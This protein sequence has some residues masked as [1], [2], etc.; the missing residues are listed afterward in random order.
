MDSPSIPAEVSEFPDDEE[1]ELALEPLT[2]S[3][4][5]APPGEPPP[6]VAWF[7]MLF[8]APAPPD[9]SPEQRAAL[10]DAGGM[11]LRFP[12][13]QPYLGAA[14]ATTLREIYGLYGEAGVAALAAAAENV[15]GYFERMGRTG[16][17]LVPAAIAAQREQLG[18]LVEQARL[19]V[20]RAANRLAVRWVRLARPQIAS[21]FARYTGL[22][23]ASA[24]ALQHTLAFQLQGP[25]TVALARAFVEVAQASEGVQHL[26]DLQRLA[27]R[28]SGG[29]AHL[30]RIARELAVQLAALLDRVARLSVRHPVLYRIWRHPAVERA[31]APALR[32]VDDA[33]AERAIGTDMA[34]RSLVVDALATA[35]RASVD[36]ER[37]AAAGEVDVWRYSALVVQTLS[38]LGVPEG[39]VEWRAV[40]ERLGQQSSVATVLHVLSAVSGAAEF[41]TWAGSAAPPVAVAAAG[42]GLVLQSTEWLLEA[43]ESVQ[44]R[45]AFDFALNPADTFGSECS[46]MGV[47]IGLAFLA[48]QLRDIKAARSAR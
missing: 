16:S 7:E 46:Y 36:M 8:Q 33:A 26:D 11:P 28:H 44:D 5:P 31:L 18:V 47:V 3:V 1:E 9:L 13:Q 37:R 20:Q 29:S 21:E 15:A 12:L 27:A 39:S 38:R 40:H 32:T 4:A 42:I 6:T 19:H 14:I 45:E 22:R 10:I 25:D 2:L 17:L 23:S 34:F 30:Q 43:G 48:L 41:A 35:W 24:A